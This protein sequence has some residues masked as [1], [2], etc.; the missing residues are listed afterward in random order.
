MNFFF[1]FY[2]YPILLNEALDAKNILGNYLCFI[3][4][5]L[6]GVSLTLRNC[7]ANPRCKKSL[8][9][10]FLLKFE[11]NSRKRKEKKHNNV[12]NNNVNIITCSLRVICF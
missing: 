7:M 1:N 2:Y 9:L 6:D 11:L 5:C 8:Q 4:D 10:Q 3:L 12:I